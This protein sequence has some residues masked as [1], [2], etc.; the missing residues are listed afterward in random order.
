MA[1]TGTHSLV[2]NGP[3]IY[4]Y[5]E[6]WSDMHQTGQYNE[7][8]AE[9][10]ANICRLLQPTEERKCVTLLLTQS[11]ET[12]EPS[13]CFKQDSIDRSHSI[14]ILQYVSMLQ[15]YMDDITHAYSKD[16]LG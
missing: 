10:Q 7:V 12:S 6:L 15:R 3:G 5:I 1:L 16:T 8:R 11:Q 4:N 9:S 13:F 14:D 2:M